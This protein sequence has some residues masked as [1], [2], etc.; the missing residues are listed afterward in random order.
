MEMNAIV[1]MEDILRWT[2]TPSDEYPDSYLSLCKFLDTNPRPT[3][4]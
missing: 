2:S 1:K 3:F 4:K